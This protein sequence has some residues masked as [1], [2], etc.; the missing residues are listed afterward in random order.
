VNA[1]QKA[2]DERTKHL[3]FFQKS[4]LKNQSLAN[5]FLDEEADVNT[6]R[7]HAEITAKNKQTVLG[8][9]AETQVNIT[10]TNAQQNNFKVEWE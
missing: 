9:D 5:R 3:I 7:T 10:N 4:A 6:L 1:V 2:I 8:K